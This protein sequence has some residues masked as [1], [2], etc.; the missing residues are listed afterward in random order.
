MLQTEIT[1][2]W[3]PWFLNQWF[4]ERAE[5]GKKKYRIGATAHYRNVCL[6]SFP[7]VQFILDFS[8]HKNDS[9]E[10]WDSLMF[11]LNDPYSSH[12]F[13]TPSCIGLVF[14][15]VIIAHW[16]QGQCYFLSLLRILSDSCPTLTRVQLFSPSI[17][18]FS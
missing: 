3:F 13:M 10:L 15:T 6:C 17:I 4:L 18:S 12:F 2:D 9:S 7:S 1:S 5:Y 11:Y 16:P 8:F 14:S